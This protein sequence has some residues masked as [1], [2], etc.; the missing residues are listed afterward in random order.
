MWELPISS[1][2]PHFS[3]EHLISGR[4]YVIEFEWIER[5]QYWV[6]HLFSD[7]EEAMALGLKV[8]LNWPIFVDQNAGLAFLLVAKTRN[9][10]LTK[11]SFH[12]DFFLVACE[13][14]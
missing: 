10:Q 4:H 7:R 5:E 8:M 2:A 6:M 11:D 14:V 12:T 13:F 9:A 3:Q 1:D